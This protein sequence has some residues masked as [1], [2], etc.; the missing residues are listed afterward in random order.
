MTVVT[1]FF[2]VTAVFAVLLTV[3]D[4]LEIG[5]ARLVDWYRLRSYPEFRIVYDPVGETHIEF[6][7]HTRVAC[8]RFETTYSQTADGFWIGCIDCFKELVEATPNYH[9]DG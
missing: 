7:G 5:A 8:G 9:L 3:W 2:I 6:T 4:L 1:L